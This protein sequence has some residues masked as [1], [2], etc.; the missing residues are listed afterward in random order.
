MNTFKVIYRKLLIIII[1]IIFYYYLLLISRM[2]IYDL[3][4]EIKKAF[5]K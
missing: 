3:K 5:K 4:S 1:I 2:N